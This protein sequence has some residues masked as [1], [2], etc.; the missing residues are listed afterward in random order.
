MTGPE[1]HKANMPSRSCKA[2][3]RTSSIRPE[4]FFRESGLNDPNFI[5]CN[6]CIYHSISGR[7]KRTGVPKA[8][9]L[10]VNVFLY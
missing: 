10:K 4:M 1:A 9:F 8:L 2:Q 3:G 7:F 6:F 5:K